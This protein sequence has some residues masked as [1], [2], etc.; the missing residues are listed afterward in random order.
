MMELD[1]NL[2]L[3][4]FFDRKKERFV[5]QKFGLEMVRI[6]FLVCLFDDGRS[7]LLGLTDQHV[8]KLVRIDLKQVLIEM[9][10]V[11]WKYKLTACYGTTIVSVNIY[12]N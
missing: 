8:E 6:L 11:L 12:S 4:L 1:S 2:L 5:G 7:V 3:Y 9:Q 10:A